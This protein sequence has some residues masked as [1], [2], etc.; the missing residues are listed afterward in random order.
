MTVPAGSQAPAGPWTPAGDSGWT[1]FLRRWPSWAPYAAAVWGVLYAAVQIAWVTTGTAL[2]LGAGRLFPPALQLALA[3]LALLAAGACLAGSRVR[4]GPALRAVGVPLIVAIPAFVLGTFGAPMEFVSLISGSGAGVNAV[5]LIHLLLDVTGAGLLVVTGLSFLRRLRGRCPRCG[6]AHSGRVDGPLVRP[7]A[8]TASARTRVT[9]Y[10]GM[11]GVLPWATV[12]TIWTL[13]GD[14]LGVTSQQWQETSVG[15]SWLMRALALVGVDFTVLSAALA[16][17]LMLGLVHPWGQ[18]F[19]RWTLF[20]AGRR[21]PRLLPLIPAW[22]AGFTLALYG[23]ALILIATPV[24]AGVGD[25]PEPRPP[26]TDGTGITWMTEF[27]GLAFAGL[28]VGLLVAARSYATRTRPVCADGSAARPVTSDGPMPPFAPAE[29]HGTR[30][31]R[32][33][34][35]RAS[36]LGT[37]MR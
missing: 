12:K 16:W 10:A 20:L 3:G 36:T 23:T 18:V 19:P 14:A 30:G 9:V 21:V 1:A 34:D 17:F 32:S 13:G 4:G 7:A 8:S 2:P 37:P 25:E 11:S 35:R 15:A 29:P 26:F 31:S 33:G 6:H 27:G 28:G 5:G 22:L 24:L